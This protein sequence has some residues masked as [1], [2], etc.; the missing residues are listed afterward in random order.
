MVLPD[1]SQFESQSAYTHTALHELGHATGHPDRLNR[2]TLVDH[3]GFGSEAYA[4]EEL[5]AEIA[6]MMTGE[7]RGVGHEPRHGTAYV[8]SWIKALE[9]DPK[10]IRPAAVDAQRI[11][12]WLM[13]RERSR[14]D[15]KADHERPEPRVDKTLQRGEPER[16]SPVAPDAQDPSAGG[17]RHVPPR[18]VTD[19]AGDHPGGGTQPRTR[20]WAEPLTIHAPTPTRKR[21]RRSR[22]V[23][24]AQDGRGSRTMAN[25]SI[26]H[27]LHGRRKSAEVRPGS[28]GSK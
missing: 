13:A 20:H 3:G 1:R 27:R 28:D 23:E 14:G 2:A 19:A 12:D 11:S 25:A 15:D 9:N 18:R 21:K 6:A 24:S 4:R 7:Q 10:E 26:E 5:R 22:W 16:S 17:P 8:S